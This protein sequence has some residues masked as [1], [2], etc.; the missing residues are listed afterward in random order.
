M[1]FLEISNISKQIKNVKAVSNISFKQQRLQRLAIVG[2]TGSGKTTLLKMIA[3]LVQ[4]TSGAMFFND[5]KIIGP[6]DQLIPGN[7]GIAFVSQHFE[8]LNNYFVKDLLQMTSKYNAQEEQQVFNIC[9]IEHVLHRKTNELSGGE[10]QR[11]ALAKQILTAPQLLLLDE[12][13]SNLDALHKQLMKQVVGDLISK[14]KLT[15]IVVSHDASDVLQWANRVIV[16]QD[17]N[18]IQDDETK[19][20][21]KHPVNEYAAA[22]LGDYFVMDTTIKEFGELKLSKSK[23]QIF[24]PEQIKISSTPTNF[25]ATIH[26]VDYYGSYLLV[27]AL[28]LAQTILLRVKVNKELKIGEEIYITFTAF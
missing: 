17:G 6:E 11:V 5:V 16:M 10:K 20:V 3:G 26:Q 24:R 12:P 23:H 9:K 28:C 4:P 18:I 25:K 27:K 1:N 19:N 13:F 2:A 21:Y 8:L 14:F 22:L 7:K 15:C